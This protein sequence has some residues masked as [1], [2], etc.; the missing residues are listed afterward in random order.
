MVGGWGW[1]E[2]VSGEKK[3]EGMIVVER[4]VECSLLEECL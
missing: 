1:V 3:A 4:C 2:R